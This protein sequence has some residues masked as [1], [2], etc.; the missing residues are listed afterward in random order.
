VGPAK[1]KTKKFLESEF[2]KPVK[3]FVFIFGVVVQQP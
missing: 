2:K 3:G 1:E